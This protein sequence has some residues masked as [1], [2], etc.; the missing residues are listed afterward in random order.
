MYCCRSCPTIIIEVEIN[1]STLIRKECI[2]RNKVVIM[3][4]T[5]KLFIDTPFTSTPLIL[6]KKYIQFI[7]LIY[8][9]FQILIYF[10]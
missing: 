1:P 5:N 6:I 2:K 7:F 8:L 10:C 9:F 3:Y 4:G